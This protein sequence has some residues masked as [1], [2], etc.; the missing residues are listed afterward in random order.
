MCCGYQ[1]R[2]LK[3]YSEGYRNDGIVRMDLLHKGEGCF[4][5]WCDAPFTKTLRDTPVMGP[6][7]I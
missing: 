5:L 6:W 4:L 2:V 1:S 7:N 3:K